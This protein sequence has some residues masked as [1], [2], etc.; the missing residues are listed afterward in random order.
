MRSCCGASKICDGGPCSTICPSSK[1][2]IRS[3][4]AR[5]KPISCVTHSIVMPASRAS[6]C[7]TSSTSLII[8]GSSAD[9]GSSNSMIFGFMARARAIATRCCWPPESCAG[10]L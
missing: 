8:S 6:D 5:A 7:M 10:Y 3:A 4:T 2:T 9:V 1:K